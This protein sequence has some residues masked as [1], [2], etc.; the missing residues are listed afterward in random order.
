M[1][2]LHVQ[3]LNLNFRL[4]AAF[5]LELWSALGYSR[6]NLNRGVGVADMEFPRGIKESAC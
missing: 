3:S 1:Q 6:K 5:T 2:I 4:T